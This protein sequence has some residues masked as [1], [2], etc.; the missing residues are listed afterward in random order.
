MTQ[1]RSA[2]KKGKR[3]VRHARIRSR[4]S[5]TADMPRLALFKSNTAVYVQLIND[6]TG[7]TIASA[8]TK[9]EKKGT[10]TEKSRSAGVAIAK[11]AQAKNISRV[12]FDRGGFIYTGVVKAL[13]DGAREGG[14]TF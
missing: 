1:I 9:T 7:V 6:T 14:L 3:V 12:V 2:T 8:S 4:V 5:G 11:A 13:A 10:M